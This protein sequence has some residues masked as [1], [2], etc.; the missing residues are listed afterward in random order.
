MTFLE[1][2]QQMEILDLV[3]VNILVVNW[4]R[5]VVLGCRLLE[6]AWCMLTS[7][8]PFYQSCLAKFIFYSL[9]GPAAKL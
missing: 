8:T 2:Q 5:L 1:F 7:E 9:E 3:S 4:K 6:H